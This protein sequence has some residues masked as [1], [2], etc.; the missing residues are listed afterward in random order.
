[1]SC[2][3]SGIRGASEAEKSQFPQIEG[4]APPA[5]LPPRTGLRS[6]YA[7][8]V[9]AVATC[10]GEAAPHLRRAPLSQPSLLAPRLREQDPV[11]TAR[12]PS[13]P[14]RPSSSCHTA[15]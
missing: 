8:E 7:Q 9:L 6:P 2:R 1:M 4:E 14:A 3:L 5:T 11:A 10:V 15:G 13:P 12:A